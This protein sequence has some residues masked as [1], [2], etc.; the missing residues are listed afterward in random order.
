MVPGMARP[1]AADVW[2]AGTLAGATAVVAVIYLGIGV[3]RLAGSDGRVLDNGWVRAGL[4]LAVVA[5]TLFARAAVLQFRRP[6][7][8]RGRSDARRASG[9]TDSPAK[10]TLAGGPG[11]HRHAAGTAGTA[12]PTEWSAAG[13]GRHAVSMGSSPERGPTRHAAAGP[14][15][16]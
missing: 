3:T 8:R 2:F 13:P 12:I 11:H 7:N 9:A 5:L 16:A 10:D 14:P 4:A 1:R 15:E 6:R